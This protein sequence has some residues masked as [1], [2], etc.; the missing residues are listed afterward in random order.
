MVLELGLA[1]N[2]LIHRSSSTTFTKRGTRVLVDSEMLPH[3]TVRI[4]PAPFAY[5]YLVVVESS[6]FEICN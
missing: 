1:M 2:A 3:E 4:I 5:L 6:H